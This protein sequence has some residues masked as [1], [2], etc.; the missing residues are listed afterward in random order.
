MTIFLTKNHRT[1]R[2]FYV[3][4]HDILLEYSGA[5]RNYFDIVVVYLLL[6]L[7]IEMLN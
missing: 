4:I 5:E 6:Y 2:I 3:K 1:Y 7:P